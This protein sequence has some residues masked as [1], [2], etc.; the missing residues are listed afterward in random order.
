MISG[1]GEEI[2]DA[3]KCLHGMDEVWRRGR[4]WCEGA[5]IE[6]VVIGN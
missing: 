4:F 1:G 3:V 5:R 2:E 6:G